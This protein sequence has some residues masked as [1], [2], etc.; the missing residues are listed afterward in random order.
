M[1]EQFSSP[2]FFIVNRMGFEFFQRNNHYTSS[3]IATPEIDGFKLLV[4][5]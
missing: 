1:S 2:Y 3:T 5:D 4:S